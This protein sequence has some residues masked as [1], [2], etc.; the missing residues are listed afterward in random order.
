MH[1]Y[2]T[3]FKPCQGEQLIVDY[4]FVFL[5]SYSVRRIIIPFSR[6]LIQFAGIIIAFS[7]NL[8]LFSRKLIL[9]A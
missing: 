4:R 9:F 6:D 2:T 3:I 7:R 1:L 5:R 8:I